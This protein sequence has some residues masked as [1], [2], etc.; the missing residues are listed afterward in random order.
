MKKNQFSKMF[1]VSMILLFAIA[2]SSCKKDPEPEP[3]KLALITEFA[4]TNAGAAGSTRVDGVINNFDIL[5]V[6]PYESNL[7]ALTTD[8]KVSTGASVVPASG[9][10]LDFSSV[11]NFV[12][13][14]GDKNNTYKVTVELAAPTSGVISAIKFVSFSSGEE[15]ETV[16]SQTEKKIT[17]TFN[18]LQNPKA[19]IS[20]I[21]LIPAGSTYTTSGSA[22]TLTLT[23]NQ[24]ITVS[25][26][27][28]NTVYQVIANITQ[29]G[30]N[31]ANTTLLMDKSGRSGLVPSIINNENIRGAAFDGRNVY[32][33]SRKDGNFVYVWDVENPSADPTEL[34]L[35]TVV[36]GGTWRVSDVRTVDNK[37]YVSNMVMNPEQIFKVYKWADKN[38]QPELILQYTLP[39]ANIRLGDAFSVIGNPP[40]NGYIFASNFAWPNNASEFYVW[41][42]NGGVAGEPVIRT[43]TPLVGLRMGQYGRVNAIPGE[44]DK[45]LVSGAEMGIAVMDFN[46]NILYESSEPMIQ[47]RSYDMRVFEYNGGLYLSY[48][49]NRE[50][51]GSTAED[52]GTYYDV[53]NITEGGDIIESLQ[54]LNNN[55][56]AEK[57]VFRHNFGA[58]AATWVGATHGIG[59]SAA[60][61]PRAMSF[62]LRNGFI[63]HEFSN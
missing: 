5:V 21:S 38:A 11:R 8:I 52:K 44:T 26:A 16:I 32:V 58:E 55:N 40:E 30:F 7:T 48:V 60:G 29:A 47:S 59:F 43:I 50:W 49:V 45:L 10:A 28:T 35:G 9:A 4:I 41:S 23:S 20:Q 62:T 61:K 13:T 42:F 6:V 63:V 1:A 46:G 2:F 56:I 31:P 12:V 33:A 24:S 14:N 15:Y 22:D 27:G 51:E 25:Y 57:R 36:E 18:D 34:A 17:V 53:I 3:E 54:N 37:I 39:G 19:V